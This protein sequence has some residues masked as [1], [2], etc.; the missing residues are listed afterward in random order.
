M[1]GAPVSA[2]RA[3]LRAYVHHV[4]GDLLKRG[5]VRRERGEAMEDV[6]RR[7]VTAVAA[8]VRED[9]EAIMV[10]LGAIAQA[11]L[12]SAVAAKAGDLVS[13]GID[14]FLEP[15]RKK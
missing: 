13:Q 7:E 12:R 15:M 11:G 14:W 8:E 3:E 10:E 4:V 6:L 9:L 2:H 1:A 5:A